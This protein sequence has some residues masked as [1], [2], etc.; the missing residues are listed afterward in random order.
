MPV[1]RR[2]R[3][4]VGRADGLLRGDTPYD[5]RVPCC[6]TGA[7]AAS[8][9]YR[10]VDGRRVTAAAS[11]RE[12]RMMILLTNLVE[13]SRSTRWLTPRA[14]YSFVS[15]CS[16]GPTM[17]L[18][19]PRF[20]RATS[21]ETGSQ[22][23]DPVKKRQCSSHM[24]VQPFG[25]LAFFYRVSGRPWLRHRMMIRAAHGPRARR[26]KRGAVS[27]TRAADRPGRVQAAR[28]CPTRAGRE[29]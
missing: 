18:Q 10:P 13:V 29:P 25:L 23:A 8:C 20:L 15:V 21:A 6:G 24:H 16:P 5:E 14:R 17:V 4:S 2:R 26:S 19:R 9:S 11:T 22:S 12:I 28:T 1:G 27:N 3:A 7:H